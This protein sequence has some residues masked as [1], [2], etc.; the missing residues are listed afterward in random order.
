MAVLTF[1]LKRFPPPRVG[2]IGDS[3]TK[4]DNEGG[5]VDRRNFQ[6]S[7]SHVSALV[8]HIV[9]CIWALNYYLNKEPIDF[10]G[11]WWYIL[12]CGINLTISENLV[13]L[14]SIWGIQKII[15]HDYQ[16]GGSFFQKIS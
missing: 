6:M 5:Y 1:K 15:T 12:Y 3:D 9:C 11:P 16:G 13:K 2:N 10:D 4:G 7:E 8:I 14:L